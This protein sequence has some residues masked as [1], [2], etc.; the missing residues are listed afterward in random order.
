MTDE[1]NSTAV[2]EGLVHIVTHPKKMANFAFETVYSVG[3][4]FI[5]AGLELKEQLNGKKGKTR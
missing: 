1:P 5:I 3:K 2:A 4:V